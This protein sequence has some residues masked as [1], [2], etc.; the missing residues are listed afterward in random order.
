MVYIGHGDTEP[1]RAVL[2]GS[3]EGIQDVGMQAMLKNFSGT[4]VQVCGFDAVMNWLWFDNYDDHLQVYIMCH[5]GSTDPVP[6]NSWDPARSSWQPLRSSWE[7]LPSSGEPPRSS[8]EPLPSLGPG[9]HACGRHPCSI[10]QLF[11]S[12]CDKPVSVDSANEAIEQLHTAVCSWPNGDNP[13]GY[14]QIPYD[15]LQNSL[16]RFQIKIT[17]AS[18]IA[19]GIPRTM[20]GLMFGNGTL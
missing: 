9:E 5:A 19:R 13:A 14:P 8:W 12:P 17:G 20:E 18:D 15:R 3:F 6:S 1:D 10:M 11:A 16:S 4:M 7:P 2:Q